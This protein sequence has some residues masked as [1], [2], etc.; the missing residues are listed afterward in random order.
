MLAESSGCNFLLWYCMCVFQ[1]LRGA[2]VDVGWTCDIEYQLGSCLRKGINHNLQ[3][4]TKL[5][6]L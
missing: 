3:F 2:W 4:P 6:I 1:G 5:N